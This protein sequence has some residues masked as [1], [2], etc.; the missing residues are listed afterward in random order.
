MK[1]IDKGI[2]DLFI[3]IAAL[4]DKASFMLVTGGRFAVAVKVDEDL[5]TPP[6]QRHVRKTLCVYD[7]EDASAGPIFKVSELG[8]LGYHGNRNHIVEQTALLKSIIHEAHIAF[9]LGD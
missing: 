3:S 8:V 5:K 6:T 9:V 1:H 7:A 2:Y 4:P